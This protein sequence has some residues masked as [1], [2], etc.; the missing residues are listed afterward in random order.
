MTTTFVYS[1]T[2]DFTN[3]KVDIGALLEEI[4]RSAIK[5]SP[6]Y[7][8]TKTQG[9]TVTV[10]FLADLDSADETVL[11]GD[12][13]PAEG[14]IGAHTGDPLENPASVAVTNLNLD[15]E[16]KLEITQYPRSGD[17]ALRV[18]HNWCDPCT[19]Y[20]QSTRHDDVTCTDTGDGL[21]WSTGHINLIDLRHGRLSFE[22][23]VKA[24]NYALS[25]EDFNLAVEVDGSPVVEHTPLAG[26]VVSD[27]WERDEDGDYWID[28]ELGEIHFKASQAGKAVTISCCVSG[29]S[30]WNLD[31]MHDGKDMDIE[32]AEAQF[33]ALLDMRSNLEVQFYG[34]VDAFAPE[35]LEEPYN[36]PSGTPIP[37]LPR[38]YTYKRLTDFIAESTSA[39]PVL[40]IIGH[41]ANPRTAPSV[42]VFPFQYQAKRGLAV[43][44][45]MRMSISLPGNKPWGGA[46]CT[47]S[48]YGLKS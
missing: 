25:G 24:N 23:D 21:K 26:Q 41:P 43:A 11:Y 45:Q 4:S 39:L 6:D 35:L 34:M 19:W 22:E 16:G 36:V 38:A 15:S 29:S 46:Y 2:D 44:G 20:Q 18:T 10:V 9:D 27:A 48:F 37:L 30:E 5:V 42:I 8:N 33:A 7:D 40:P 12:V 17:E 13:S 14:L 31:V 28:H 47:V 1:Q 3:Q 32:Y